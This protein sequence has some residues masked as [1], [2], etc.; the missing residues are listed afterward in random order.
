V[1]RYATRWVV[2]ERPVFGSRYSGRRYD[3]RYSDR[4]HDD[5]RYDDRRYDD[6]RYRRQSNGAYSGDPYYDFNREY[7]DRSYHPYDDPR[8]GPR[9]YDRR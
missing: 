7:W 2:I 5:R 1:R 6:R 8:Y 9:P 3:R 4:R